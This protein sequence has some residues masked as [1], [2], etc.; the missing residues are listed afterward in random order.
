MAQ[1]SVNRRA[2]DGS[3]YTNV[4]RALLLGSGLLFLAAAL[5]YGPQ[6]VM[7][8]RGAP[9]SALEAERMRGVR[10]GF[11]IA[12]ALLVAASALV[13]RWR[14]LRSLAAGRRA[15]TLLL[16]VLALTVPAGLVEFALRPFTE[17]R[18]TLFTPDRELG[19]RLVPGARDEWGGVRVAINARGMRG[20]AL[21]HEKPDGAARILFLGDS[22]TF[23][24][25]V[26]RDEDLF[27]QGV[28]RELTRR[29]GRPVEIVNAGVGGYSPWQQALF[30]ER[31]G[32]RYAPDLVVVG[33]VLNDVTEKLAL[34]RYEARGWQLERTARSALDRWL[35]GSAVAAWLGDA[36][37]RIRFGRDVSAGAL[38]E[39]AADVR[40]LARDPEAP[41]W[42]RA[43]SITTGNLD[44]IFAFA[45]ARE[46]ESVLVI[47]PYAFQLDAPARSGGPQRRL[48]AHARDRGVP[49][50]DL[51]PLLSA[52]RDAAPDFIDES[53]LSPEGHR[54]VAAALADFVMRQE[55]LSPRRDSS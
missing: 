23:G 48:L 54:A 9:P 21:D 6:L 37:A 5:L 10:I 2:E 53:H 49:V 43:W 24:Y 47:F 28:G 35:S 3:E 32:V 17:P 4:V 27:A 13:D 14:R 8:C 25:G 34:V 1:D 40:R 41:A 7:S 36:L 42:R 22:V 30:F 33:F 31:E 26:E 12:G 16:A 46:I 44:R 20:P 38:R 19:W 51:L 39:E 45:A 55:L 11:A 50:L 29:L 18:T 52:R 15:A